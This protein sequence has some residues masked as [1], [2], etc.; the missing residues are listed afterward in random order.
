MGIKVGRIVKEFV[1]NSLIDQEI[2]IEIHGNKKELTGIITSVEEEI[3]SLNIIRGELKSFSAGESVRIFFFFQNNYHTFDSIIVEIEESLLK[4]QHPDGVYK[5]PQRKFERIKITEQIQVFFTLKGKKIELNFPESRQKKTMEEPEVPEDFDFSSIQELTKNFRKKMSESVSYNQ[6]RMLRNKIPSSYEE[7]VM[8]ATGKIVWI[9]SSEEDFPFK[10]PFPDKRVIT[11]REL[12]KYEESFDTPA[13]IITSKLGNL[14]YEK[15]KKKIFSEV[16]CPILYNQY[17]IG[18]IYCVN[19][20]EKK[21]KI[22]GELVDY[23]YQFSKVLSYSLQLS[24]Y[25]STETGGESRYEATILEMS[26]SGLLFCYPGEELAK[27]LIIHTDL[28]LTIKLQDRSIVIGSRVRRKFK[29]KEFYYYG[30]Q[31][32]KLDPDDFNF[33]FEMLY[34]RP[35]SADEEDRWEGGAPPPPLDL[36]GE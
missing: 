19:R 17:I 8:V 35:I 11:K 6:V 34:G 36:F 29:D 16:Y 30:V 33:I 28:D 14:L 3:L 12:V 18:Y 9:P 23:I 10:D 13:Y 5:N 21:E 2:E 4:I 22:S 25:F 26:A 31:F 24:G 7:K 15:Q 27:D 1:F 20:D 32:L